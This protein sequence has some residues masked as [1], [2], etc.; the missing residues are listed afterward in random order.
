MPYEWRGNTI[1]DLKISLLIVI[2]GNGLLGIEGLFQTWS[3]C[4]QTSTSVENF[5]VFLK[6]KTTQCHNCITKCLN[7]ILS[8]NWMGKWFLTTN[9]PKFST[10][11][12]W[13]TFSFWIVWVITGWWPGVGSEPGFA[14]NPCSTKPMNPCLLP[15]TESIESAKP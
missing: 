3:L 1:G 15:S 14:M 8:T 12:L 9:K 7:Q 6:G 4:L 2:D 5:K 13:C 11:L 10:H